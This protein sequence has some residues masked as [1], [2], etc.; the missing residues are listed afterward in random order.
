VAELAGKKS[1]QREQPA[2]YSGRAVGFVAVCT[3]LG[4]VLRIGMARRGGLWCDEAQFLWIVRIPTL[5]GMLDF[6]W[7]H[8]SH[9]PLFYVLMRGWLG[10]FGDSEPAALALPI[11]FGA[12]LVPASYYVGSRVF[13]PQ[14]G[15]IAA[16]LVTAAP[17]LANDSGNVRPYS[18]LSLLCLGAVYLLWRGLGGGGARTWAAQAGITLAMLLIHHWAWM[19]FGAEATVVVICLLAGRLSAAILR[20]WLLAQVVA[21]AG[22]APWAPI[23]LH[24]VRYAGYGPRPVN[25]LEAIAVF[26]EMMTSLHLMV[27]LVLVLAL[28]AA[29]ARR[30]MGRSTGENMAPFLDTWGI[31]LLLF[32]GI[33]VIAFV[34]AVL[35]SYRNN[36]YLKVPSPIMV[37]PCIIIVIAFLISSLSSWPRLLGGLLTSTYVLMSLT[38]LGWQKANT[39]ALA[40]AIAARA[41][42]SDI[43][44]I[45]PCW[46]SSSFDYYFKP[47]NLQI[48]YPHNFA[49]GAIFYDRIRDRLLDPKPMSQFRSEIEQ[50]YRAGRR[51]WLVNLNEIHGIPRIPPENDEVPPNYQNLTYPDLGCSRAIQ[52][53]EMIE[54]KFGKSTDEICPRRNRPGIEILRASL[55]CRTDRK[56]GNLVIHSQSRRNPHGRKRRTGLRWFAGDVRDQRRDVDRPPSGLRCRLFEQAG[57][58]LAS[59]LPIHAL[60][61]SRA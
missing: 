3:L 28:F 13:S 57:R 46:F 50:A 43:V 18:L 59:V 23:L 7:H 24:Q 38:L 40:E 55:Y 47:K 20:R 26:A 22:Y 58:R 37:A 36:L 42:P 51:I 56:T 10:V 34:A 19:V 4:F 2:L 15:L 25:V 53:T 41:E 8:E 1:E 54:S 12:A 16:L 52:I 30:L 35:L 21:I 60:V 17:L 45:T 14:A 39:S 9:P 11:L 48:V 6:L 49:E 44:V 61:A 32:A 5:G 29:V 27:V 33:P 31:A